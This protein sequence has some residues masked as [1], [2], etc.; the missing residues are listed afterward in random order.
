MADIRGKQTGSAATSA[1]EEQQKRIYA[2]LR[3]EASFWKDECQG[4]WK[5]VNDLQDQI[6]DWQGEA[7]YWRVNGKIQGG[8][9]HV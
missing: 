8:G 3:K 5:S 6:R 7:N 9:D 2:D 1:H 4:L